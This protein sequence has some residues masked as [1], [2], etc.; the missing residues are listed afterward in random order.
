M[1][2]FA[3]QYNPSSES[4]KS[5]LIWYAEVPAVSSVVPSFVGGFGVILNPFVDVILI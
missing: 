1:L 2:G 3:I 4:G 5:V